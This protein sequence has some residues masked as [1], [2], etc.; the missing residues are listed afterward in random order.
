[1]KSIPVQS[2]ARACAA[3]YLTMSVLLR[4]A[5]RQNIRAVYGVDVPSIP[6][7]IGLL[8]QDAIS[9]ES[10]AREAVEK[11]VLSIDVSLAD[12]RDRYARELRENG[13]MISD[14]LVGDLLTVAAVAIAVAALKSRPVREQLD[15]TVIAAAYLVLDEFADTRGDLERH[16]VAVERALT[17]TDVPTG[18][19]TD[20]PANDSQGGIGPDTS[21]LVYRDAQRLL[22]LL[23]EAERGHRAEVQHHQRRLVTDE[24]GKVDA[25]RDA[26]AAHALGQAQSLRRMQELLTAVVPALA[27]DLAPPHDEAGVLPLLAGMRDDA[28]VPTQG[29][30]RQFVWGA[31]SV[32]GFIPTVFAGQ[33]SAELH[34]VI[35]EARGVHPAYDSAGQEI[36][37]RVS[38]VLERMIDRS[39]AAAVAKVRVDLFGEGTPGASGL[40]PA[41]VGTDTPGAGETTSA[42]FGTVS[43]PWC[44]DEQPVPEPAEN[45]AMF[46]GDP[47]EQICGNCDGR[48]ELRVED[49]AHLFARIVKRT[50]AR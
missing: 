15:D 26:L 40:R 8:Y 35:P 25:T 7:G 49:A 33:S 39:P 50:G 19:P 48:Y 44:G 47:V 29:P 21:V 5:F 23:H 11:L 17:P 10:Q 30:P 1:M 43:C 14:E 24:S 13:H 12:L 41:F 22:A 38:A 3:V 34:V 32:H 27:A 31:P 2:V 4:Q 18:E 42:T 37:D 6:E 20:A 16:A 9:P 36:A 45:P 28:T 46:A